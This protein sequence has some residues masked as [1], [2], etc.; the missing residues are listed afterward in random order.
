MQ[1]I[2]GVNIVPQ[3]LI[4]KAEKIQSIP[5]VPEYGIPMSVHLIGPKHPNR[6]GSRIFGSHGTSVDGYGL[7]ILENR[8]T[9]V[10]VYIPF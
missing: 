10:S 6:C 4:S 8:S 7:V 2:P 5:A 3:D 1:V 9:S